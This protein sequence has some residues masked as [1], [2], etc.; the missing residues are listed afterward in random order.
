MNAKFIKTKLEQYVGK[1][2]KVQYSL[3]RNKYEKYS[4]KITQLFP[5]VFLFEEESGNVKC[6]SYSDILTKTIR[7]GIN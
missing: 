4:G 3:G 5:N 2:I 7:L 6:F 1:L